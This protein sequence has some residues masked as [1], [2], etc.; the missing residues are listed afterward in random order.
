[1]K[2]EGEDLMERVKQMQSK[3]RSAFAL[4]VAEFQKNE[5]TNKEAEEEA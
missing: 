5:R 3:L 2:K 1:M 4:K